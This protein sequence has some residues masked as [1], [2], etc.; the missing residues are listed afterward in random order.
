MIRY[1]YT[2]PLEDRKPRNLGD[3][4]L[5]TVAPASYGTTDYY[6]LSAL[7]W[8][9]RREEEACQVGQPPRFRFNVR[10]Q[11][12][13]GFEDREIDTLVISASLYDGLV[14]C[15]RERNYHDDSDFYAVIWNPTSR[16]C[17]II[18][19]ATTRFGGGGFCQIDATDEVKAAA[20]EYL[21]AQLID[22]LARDE[23]RRASYVEKGRVVRF[24]RDY[25]PRKG[26]WAG[27]TIS[28]GTLAR[29]IWEGF[30]RYDPRPRKSKRYGV[31][32][33]DAPEDAEPLWIG[34]GV[35]EVADPTA[36]MPPREEIEA[37]A[38]RAAE[39]DAFYL[40]FTDPQMVVVA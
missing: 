6:I 23:E 1:N 24:T 33:L 25:R 2:V 31:K 4:I 32:L 28:A 9:Y 7:G 22:R 16:Q 11:R 15:D 36:Y 20:R 12:V 26:A 35:V 14:L 19:Y 18:E 3:V 37:A 5:R 39:R 21:A 13:Y 8:M 34:Q 10:R 29:V 38:R 30:N 27:H 17:E 40:L